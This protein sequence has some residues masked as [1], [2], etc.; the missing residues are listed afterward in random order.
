MMR[1]PHNRIAL[2]AIGI[3]LAMPVTAKADSYTYDAQGRLIRVDYSAGGYVTYS[4]DD[5]GNRAVQAKSP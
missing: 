4:Y 1:R 5:A 3:G 2:F